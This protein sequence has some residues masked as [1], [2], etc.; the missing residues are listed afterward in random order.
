MVKLIA[1]TR[2]D[3][4]AIGTRTAATRVMSE[5]LSWWAD[6]DEIVL[7]TVILDRTDHDFGWIMLVRDKVGRFRCADVEASLPSERIAT[8]RLRVA[9]AEKIREPSFPGYVE[10]GDEPDTPLDL[11][12]DRGIPDERLHKYFI[13]VRDR[14]GRSPAKKVFQ[15][16]SPWLLSS[17]PHLVKEFQES[18]FDQRLWEIY[19]WAMFR[20]QG[21]DAFHQ[22]AP[23]LIIR[24]PWFR[25]AV[26]ATTVG[27]STAGPLARHPEPKTPEEFADFLTNYMPMKFGSALTSKLN[28]QDAD[29]RHYW[30]KPGLEEMPFVLAIADFH[31]DASPDQLGSMTYSQGGLYCYLYGTR[32]SV[33]VSSGRP[34]IRNEPVAEHTYNGK[35]VP[36][37]FFDQPGAENVAAVLFSN[38]ATLAKFD[39]LGVLAGFAPKNHRYIRSGFQFDPDPMALVGI[40]FVIDVQDPRY[41]EFWGDEV[42]VFHNPRAKRS[43][44]LEALP[45]AAHHFF[46]DG[47]LMSS[48]RAGRVLGS[49]TAIL[50]L[51]ESLG[52]DSKKASR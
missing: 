2:F 19:L 51:T 49:T 22:Q 9:M 50:H 1:R 27:P 25:F 45:D 43:L 52:E 42:Q 29:G 32:V 5:E 37:G 38:A 31:K 30:E 11:F 6:L 47:Q 44:P 39:R 21:Y 10:Q 14:E 24:S 48:D 12:V 41:D 18:Q 4:L 8:A 40:P 34:V 46:Q 3:L 20:D 16:I 33:D 26:E 13:E 35:T 23:D 17:D 36:S 15:A 7:G 28:K